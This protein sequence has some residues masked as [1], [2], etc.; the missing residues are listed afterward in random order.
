MQQSPTADTRRDPEL[1]A[2]IARKAAISRAGVLLMF[3]VY[4]GYMGLL[5]FAP[6]VLAARVGH[7][8]IGIPLGIGVL[9]FTW[10]LTGAYVRWANGAYDAV[11]ARQK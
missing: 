10:L 1:L 4:F 2:L 6:Q 3:A 8:T 9:V 11:V 7:A 5:A